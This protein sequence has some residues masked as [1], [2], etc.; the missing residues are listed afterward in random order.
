VAYH[1]Y[2]YGGYGLSDCAESP[3]GYALC[4]EFRTD[5]TGPPKNESE[6]SQAL[7]TVRKEYPGATVKTSTFD[8]FIA[9]VLPAK[10]SLP[11]IELEVITDTRIH[12][13]L[14]LTL[15]VILA[16]P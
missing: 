4:T 13:T 10:D 7:D 2:G 9:D 15:T 14:N 8:A 6:V 3:N 1:P 5:N 16:L 11:V 12:R